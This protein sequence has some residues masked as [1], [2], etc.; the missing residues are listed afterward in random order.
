[1]KPFANDFSSRRDLDQLTKLPPDRRHQM[2]RELM[3]KIHSN[4]GSKDELDKWQMR[5][6][7]DVLRTK[8]TLM[9]TV[10]VHF[11]EVSFCFG[12]RKTEKN[13]YK[14]RFF[15]KDRKVEETDNG[16]DQSIKDC[17]PLQAIELRNWCLF[18]VQRDQQAANALI[19]GIF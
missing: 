8:A 1:M 3:K 16:W 19:D 5:F 7:S 11:A 18:F 12:K 2:I 9:K 14:T 4:D 13:A 6:E 10:T 15:F 17:K